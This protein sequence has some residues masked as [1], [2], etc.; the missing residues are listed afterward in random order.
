[1]RAQILAGEGSDV[2]GGIEHQ[3]QARIDI[4]R[5]Q[6]IGLNSAAPAHFA[7]RIGFIR[8]LVHNGGRVQLAPAERLLNR[9]SAGRV[10]KRRGQRQAAIVRKDQDMLDQTFS[11]SRLAQDRRTVVILK[12]AVRISGRAGGA[13]P[14]TKTAIGK[15]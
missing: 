3:A 8:S 11:V 9:P 6:L 4:R 5:H 7:A 1:M 2:A 13:W 12:G 10:V 14:S 15:I